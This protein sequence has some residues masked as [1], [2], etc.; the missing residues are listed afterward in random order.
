[1]AALRSK[2]VAKEG[3]AL[4]LDGES[5]LSGDESESMVL[6]T[7]RSSRASPKAPGTFLKYWDVLGPRITS[8]GPKSVL[9]GQTG[10][11]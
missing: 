10:E 9:H 11:G 5:D 7:P 6:F 3:E 2:K 4:G 8:I 1:M